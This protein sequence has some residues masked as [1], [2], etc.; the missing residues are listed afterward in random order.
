M[1]RRDDRITLLQ[2]ADRVREIEKIG[3]DAALGVERDD[4]MR[5][6]ALAHLVGVLSRLARRVSEERRAA[7]PEISW[8]DIERL[9]HHAVEDP[10]RIDC[11][12]LCR[13]AR[14]MAP[15][16]L[17]VLE[18]LRRQGAAREP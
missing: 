15:P 17:L 2:M 16:L 6:F 9:G 13:F 5:E 3:R 8:Q 10:D 1:S 18:Q 12:A 4:R 11:E 7:H 14:D